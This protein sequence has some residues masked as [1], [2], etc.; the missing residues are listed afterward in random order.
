LR[1]RVETDVGM[2]MAGHIDERSQRSHQCA[3]MLAMAI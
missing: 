1:V 2:A 3:G